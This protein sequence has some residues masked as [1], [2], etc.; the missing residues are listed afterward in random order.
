M[1][2]S[3][4]EVGGGLPRKTQEKSVRTKGEAV[5]GDRDREGGEGGGLL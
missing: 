3:A 5:K 1:S 4:R 2:P